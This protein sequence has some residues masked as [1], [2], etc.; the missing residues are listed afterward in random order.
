MAAEVSRDFVGGGPGGVGAE[1]G[2]RFF[3][4]HN[5]RGEGEEAGWISHGE[6]EGVR[7]VVD[8]GRERAQDR[9]LL[10]GVSDGA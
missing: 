9:S 2:D 4:Q 6:E 1:S 3:Y 5:P 7:L 10:R 8:G